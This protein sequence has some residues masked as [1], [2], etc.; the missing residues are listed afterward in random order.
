[1]S[2]LKNKSIWS[3]AMD[4]AIDVYTLVGTGHISSNSELQ[5][6]IRLA[7]VA[8]PS[9]IAQAQE[10]RV[11]DF[12]QRYITTSRS[13]CTSL[14]QYLAIALDEGL[15]ELQDVGGINARIDDIIVALDRQSSYAIAV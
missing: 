13:S 9:A 8:I 3:Q 5:D 15:L 6:Q 10:E 12:D 2:N 1:M 4:V 14:K 7:A 11:L